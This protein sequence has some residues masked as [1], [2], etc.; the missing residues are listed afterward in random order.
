[1]FYFGEII[2]VPE[3]RGQG[4]A[5]RIFKL[6]EEYAKEQEYTGTCFLSVIR[7][8]G[9]PLKPL[10]YMDNDAKWRR[11]GYTKTELTTSYT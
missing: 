11:L 2:I 3:Y 6:Q 1:M 10:G 5:S 7:E 9:H 8:E 4:L